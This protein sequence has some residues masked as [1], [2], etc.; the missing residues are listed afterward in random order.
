VVEIAEVNVDLDTPQGASRHG[1]T[2]PGGGNK[3]V[4]IV[5]AG[6]QEFA[7]TGHQSRKAITEDGDIRFAA[8]DAEALTADATVQAEPKSQFACGFDKSGTAAPKDPLLHDGGDMGEISL[9]LNGFHSGMPPIA[10]NFS[11][12]HYKGCFLQKQPPT[13]QNQ[14]HF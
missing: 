6:T 12:I 5:V 1:C 11:G 3:T 9:D 2:T 14:V 4:F 7:D 8:A 13:L 10:E